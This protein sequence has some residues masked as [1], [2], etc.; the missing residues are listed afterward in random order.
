MVQHKVYGTSQWTE[1][2]AS[3]D[4]GARINNGEETAATKRGGKTE[5]GTKKETKGTREENGEQRRSIE[6]LLEFEETFRYPCGS[7]WESL[8]TRS[9]PR[10]PRRAKK[11]HKKSDGGH[12]LVCAK[13]SPPK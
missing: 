13:Q 3:I 6:K 12:G 2:R 5:K 9:P 7:F 10:W 11:R 4:N 1:W 8:A